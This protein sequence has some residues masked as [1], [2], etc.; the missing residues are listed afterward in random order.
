LLQGSITLAEAAKRG[1]LV[2]VAAV[3]VEHA[4]LPVLGA[5]FEPRRPAEAPEGEL[6]EPAPAARRAT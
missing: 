1:G 4:L 5:L 6:A 2:L 3:I